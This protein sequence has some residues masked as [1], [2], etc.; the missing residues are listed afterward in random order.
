MRPLMENK[1]CLSNQNLVNVKNQNHRSSE[2][3]SLRD[4]T[5]SPYLAKSRFC[6]E[7]VLRYCLETSLCPKIYA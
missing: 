3:N 1:E 6:F 5:T 7:T 2:L 4:K